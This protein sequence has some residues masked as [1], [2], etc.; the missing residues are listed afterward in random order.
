M[1]RGL[2][3]DGLKYTE[4][5]L[6]HQAASFLQISGL[7]QRLR[8]HLETVSPGSTDIR[9]LLA[10]L[11]V[12]DVAVKTLINNL[13]RLYDHHHRHEDM[14]GMDVV[15]ELVKRQRNIKF[16]VMFAETIKRRRTGD[17]VCRK[18]WC[19]GRDGCCVHA[20]SSDLNVAEK[21]DDKNNEYVTAPE[22]RSRS[23][24]R[25]RPVR[26]YN[27]SYGGERPERKAGLGFSPHHHRHAV[28]FEFPSRSPSPLKTATSTHDRYSSH[29]TTMTTA[30]ATS[31]NSS[32]ATKTH[33][34]C[35]R[36]R[37]SVPSSQASTF[38]PSRPSS[39]IHHG[40]NVHDSHSDAR[41]ST[42]TFTSSASSS[43]TS[44]LSSPIK[45]RYESEEDSQGY[46]R[47]WKE[48]PDL[49]PTPREGRREQERGRSKKGRNSGWRWGWSSGWCRDAERERGGRRDREG[50]IRKCRGKSIDIDDMG[51]GLCCIVL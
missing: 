47:L 51:G 50:K 36:R 25:R 27:C 14:E 8:H 18:E 3:L 38:V 28:D 49:S 48:D 44:L 16:Q 21:P 5:A 23:F 32:G 46:M 40:D 42:S 6:L 19:C 29:T 13:A 12:D 45:T 2:D 34:R 9:T 24:E 11:P 4:I 37:S 22:H 33:R 15:V 1:P 10:S 31:T 35:R 17:C 30:T 20:Q 7:E 39:G 26:G 41:T 43:S